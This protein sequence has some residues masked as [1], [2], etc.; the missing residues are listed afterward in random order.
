METGPGR[1]KPL[2][3]QLLSMNSRADLYYWN[4]PCNIWFVALFMYTAATFLSLCT[5]C[6]GCAFTLL[7]ARALLV[8]VGRSDK[9]D[10]CGALYLEKVSSVPIEGTQPPVRI[11]VLILATYLFKAGSYSSSFQTQC[12]FSKHL[13]EKDHSDSA[14]CPQLFNQIIRGE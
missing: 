4:A 8:Y 3:T 11:I 6:V 1:G 2:P 7:L 5:S 9:K 10:S 14:R 12:T 13:R